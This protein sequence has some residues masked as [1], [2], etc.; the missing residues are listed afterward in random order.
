M[1]KARGFTLIEIAVVLFIVA[2]L[3]GAIAQYLSGQ[4]TSAKQA[5]THT[6]EAAIKAAIVS[7][8]SRNFRLPCPAIAT[9]PGGAANNGVEAI[10]PGTC[11]GSGLFPVGTPTV[12]SGTIPWAS[13]GLPAETSIDGYGNRFTYQVTLAATSSNLTAQTLP[14]MKGNITIH[15]SGP[16]AAGNQINECTPVSIPPVTYNPCSAVVVV[17]SHGINGFGA[18]MESGARVPL[19]P[20][21]DELGN[22]DGDNA[23]VMKT[24]SGAQANPYDDT[25]LFL[26]AADILAGLNNSGALQDYRAIVASNMNVIRNAIVANVTRVGN[27]LCVAGTCAGTVNC[28]GGTPCETTQFTYT[29]P[30]AGGIAPNTMP[31]VGLPVTVVNDPWGNPMQYAITTSPITPA[32]ALNLTAFTLTSWGPDGTAGNGDDISVTVSVGEFQTIVSKSR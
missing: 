28:S 21:P 16:G 4:I 30:A 32:S 2:L 6:R 1:K 23:F 22:T 9:I 11:T 31:A 29:L 18:Y 19:P 3:V 12:A 13:L 10:N 25:V 15:S 5:I 17:V 26:T 27:F 7:F 14:G 8:V 24:F 20:G